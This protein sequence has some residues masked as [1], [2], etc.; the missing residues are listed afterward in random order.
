MKKSDTKVHELELRNA[1]FGIPSVQ[2]ADLMNFY[3]QHFQALTEQGF[4]RFLYGLEKRQIILPIGAGEYVFLDKSSQP[5]AKKKRFSPNWS[6]E[7]VAL[8]KV[9]QAAFPYLQYLGWETRVLH[10]FMI[11]QPARNLFIIETEKDVCESVFNHLSRQYPGR[12][13]LDPDRLTME[14]YVLQQSDH[15]LVSRLITQT[16]RKIVYGIPFPKLEKILVDIFADGERYFFFQGEELAHIYENAFSSYWI[17]EK[18]L[19]RYAG[20]RKV[21]MKLHQF[22]SK[23]TQIKLLHARENAE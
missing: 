15:I 3:R 18:T 11:H 16:P 4:R 1:F 22:I 13:F 2:K 19:F 20:R 14:R 8:N 5:D 21:S 10:E 23:Q 12:I 7:L 6:Q 17:N 9:V